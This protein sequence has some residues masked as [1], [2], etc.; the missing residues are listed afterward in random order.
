MTTA[1]DD[2]LFSIFGYTRKEPTMDQSKCPCCGSP[3]R[4]QETAY[5]EDDESLTKMYYIICNN[6]RCD[7]ATPLCETVE[8]ADEIWGRIHSAVE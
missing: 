8:D 4:L 6:G 3:A 5:I 1:V 2:K 7:F